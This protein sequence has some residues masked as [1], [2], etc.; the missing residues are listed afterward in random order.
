MR[1][2][3]VG[4]VLTRPTHQIERSAMNRTM[5]RWPVL[6]ALMVLALAGTATAH[7]TNQFVVQL[8][9]LAQRTG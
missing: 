9:L 4:L 1:W 7:A 2:R 6:A 8:R 3:R 5:L